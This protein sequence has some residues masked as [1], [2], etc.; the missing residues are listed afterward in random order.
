MPLFQQ[1]ELYID[2]DFILDS[3][4]AALFTPVQASFSG[5]GSPILLYIDRRGELVCLDIL[6]TEKNKNAYIT[7]GIGEFE[8]HLANKE[9]K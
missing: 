5:V 8:K 7:G 2:R 6:N 1:W 4:G 9:A 3:Q